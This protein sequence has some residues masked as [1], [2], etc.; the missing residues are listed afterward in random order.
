MKGNKKFWAGLG[1]GVALTLLVCL[2]ILF[3]QQSVELSRQ[4]RQGQ[5]LG[6]PDSQKDD[7]KDKDKDSE[8][9]ASWEDHQ[10]G[11]Q[12]E[13]N[14]DTIGYKLELLEGLL[15]SYYLNDFSAKDVEDGL[16]KGLVS[17]LGDPYTVYYTAEEY[18]KFMEST[19]G[20]Y[21]GIGVMV[22]QNVQTGIITV[23]RAFTNGSSYEQGI[24]PGD[25]IYKVEDEE[26]TGIDLN[27]VVSRI[28]GEEGTFVNVTVV[29][30]GESDY[31]DFRLER[32]QIEVDTIEYEMLEDS[33][34]YIT[35]TEFDEVTADQFR[36]AL[37]DLEKKGMKGLIIDV[38]DNPGGLLDKVCDMLDR[39]L[40]KGLIVYT[41]NK[42]GERSEEYS[43]DKES[44]D[45]PLVV[46]V[47]GNS[48]SASEIF[49]GAIQD[50]GIGT[51]LG[52][53]TFGKGIVQTILP[54]NDGTAMKV[55]ISKYFTPK[56]TNIHGVG[57]TPDV[58]L[59][60]DEEMKK[61]AVVPKEKDNQLQEAVKL[62]K[63]G[64]GIQE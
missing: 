29:R 55:T 2:G 30:E 34:G 25:I 12:G 3:V 56:G 51:I 16:Y 18:A 17:S 13:L 50:Y 24:L 61:E 57:I 38:R 7:K 47:N 33:I 37:D 42:Y 10:T 32:R 22:S 11:L 39:L 21:C 41:E 6:N 26:V 52:T 58:E 28:K 49:A 63:K 1:A 31:L 4:L 15:E 64:I 40:P 53:Q 59:D 9:R 8:D 36:A 20:T 35:I 45:K 27:T 48:A 62:I 43:T 5:T 14:W 54:L 60:L 19:S 23:V 46:L 44:F